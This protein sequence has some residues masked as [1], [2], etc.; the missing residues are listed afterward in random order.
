MQPD[1]P[2][3]PS[4]RRGLAAD[5][6]GGV[7]VEFAIVA[8][9]LIAILAGLVDLVTISSI[10]RDIERSSTQIAALLTSCT[11]SSDQSCLTNT[12]NLYLNREANVL[13]RYDPNK[14]R[15]SIA[16]ISEASGALRIC[17]GNMTYLDSDVSASAL[18]LLGDKDNAIVVLIQ[19][20]Y[21]ALFQSITRAFT[22]SAVSSL[23]G[24]TTAV[25]S[26]GSNVC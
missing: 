12:I 8:T 10:N 13:V 11:R 6:R 9:I 26:S 18:N 14:V 16:Q 7:A 2:A 24:W 20:D 17:A 22:G 21:T 5:R 25:Q 15:V 19:I 23:R 1:L 3:L 4:A